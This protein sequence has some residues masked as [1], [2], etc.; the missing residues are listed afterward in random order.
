ML[1]QEDLSCIGARGHQS[2]KSESEGLACM[3]SLVAAGLSGFHHS[4]TKHDQAAAV[5]HDRPV[6][7]VF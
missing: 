3:P 2:L 5:I 7:L 1:L 6:T 4:Q